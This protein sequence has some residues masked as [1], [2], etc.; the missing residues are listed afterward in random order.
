[1]KFRTAYDSTFHVA[2]PSGSRYRQ[3]YV[4]IVNPD[5]TSKLKDAGKEDVY[6]SIQKA[7]LGMSIEDLIRRARNGDDTAIGDP[8]ESFADLSHMPTDLL[9]AH[10]ML[11][12]AKDKYLQLPAELRAKFGNSFDKFL[13]ASADGSAIRTLQE[14]KKSSDPGVQPLTADEISKI[15]ASIGGNNA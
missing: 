9:S 3:N 6:D 15:R 10:Q 5:G 13:Q 12:D 11:L 7:A 2:N 14:S 8:V 4:K 1:M